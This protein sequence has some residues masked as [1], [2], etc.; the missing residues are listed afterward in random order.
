M[1]PDI[2]PVGVEASMRLQYGALDHLSRADFLREIDIART[3]ERTEPGYL[4]EC[5]ES[6]DR[7][8]AFERWESERQ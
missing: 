2:N 5:A 4:R 6:Y 3:A 7:K 8:A 1:D